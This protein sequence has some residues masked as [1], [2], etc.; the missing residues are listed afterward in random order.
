MKLLYK[1]LGFILTFIGARVAM[2]LFRGLWSAAGDEEAPKP[3]DRDRSWREVVVAASVQGALF[4]ATKAVVDRAGATWWERIT[5]VWP[6]RE[7][8]RHR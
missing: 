1:P 7:D 6:G 8:S 4:G 5:G 3:K 2:R